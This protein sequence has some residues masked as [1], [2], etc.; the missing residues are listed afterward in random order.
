MFSLASGA[1]EAYCQVS[2]IMGF[3]ENRLNLIFVAYTAERHS[4]RLGILD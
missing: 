4:E 3:I 1:I 2:E